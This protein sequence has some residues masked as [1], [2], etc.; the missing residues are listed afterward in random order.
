MQ[1]VKHEAVSEHPAEGKATHGSS[2]EGGVQRSRV[3]R[4]GPRRP[5]GPP[6]GPTRPGPEGLRRAAGARRA[7]A[8]DEA[9]GAAASQGGQSGRRGAEINKEQSPGPAQRAQAPPPD[10]SPLRAGSGAR[11]RPLTRMRL[12]RLLS[13]GGSCTFGIAAGGEDRHP[14]AAFRGGGPLRRV[15]RRAMG[16]FMTWSGGRAGRWAGLAM[17]REGDLDRTV[18]TPAV[19]PAERPR[20]PRAARWQPGPVPS[21]GAVCACARRLAAG[22]GGGLRTA[23]GAVSAGLGRFGHWRPGAPAPRRPA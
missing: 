5:R 19:R 20:L 6:P 14:G 15:G 10:R 3:R 7:A 16:Q 22:D 8:G 17:E 13:L 2:G 1:W 11:P 4:R 21:S 12:K 9:R 18:S 23:G